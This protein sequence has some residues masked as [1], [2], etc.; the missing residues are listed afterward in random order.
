MLHW[1]ITMI[2]ECYCFP[3]YTHSHLSTC[4]WVTYVEE[5]VAQGN[6]HEL[7]C[8]TNKY[9]QTKNVLLCIK[10][11]FNTNITH[12]DVKIFKHHGKQCS[13][14]LGRS[15]LIWHPYSHDD[16]LTCIVK[17]SPFFKLSMVINETVSF[18]LFAIIC[19]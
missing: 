11:P 9:R 5:D 17:Y 3:S 19:Q 12:E 4:G 7:L 16:W 10:Y 1:N 13:I 2:W 6:L 8:Q 14:A 15:N 18:F